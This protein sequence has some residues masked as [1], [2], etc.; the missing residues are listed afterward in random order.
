[1]WDL[2]QRL[3]GKI[4][5]LQNL[6]KSEIFRNSKKN[7]FFTYEAVKAALLSRPAGSPSKNRKPTRRCH[8]EN[9]KQGLY[10]HHNHFICPTNMEELQDIRPLQVCQDE[11]LQ[12]YL[13][14]LGD[15]GRA[16]VIQTSTYW[17][18]MRR[19]DLEMRDR[20]KYL[21][22]QSW[23]Q[24]LIHAIGILKYHPP[25]FQEF[26]KEHLRQQNELWIEYGVEWQLKANAIQKTRELQQ[27]LCRVRQEREDLEEQIREKKRIRRACN[28]GRESDEETS[29]T[30]GETETEE[31][32]T[33]VE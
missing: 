1:M 29:E 26:M 7:M 2:S 20:L 15:G 10:R 5:V 33:D 11:S 22:H 17:E 4:Q 24:D 6:T 30:E 25:T 23:D 8:S 32:G 21:Y 13:D 31:E 14:S 28:R 16:Y 19:T 18:N 3:S 27:E 12:T 9:E